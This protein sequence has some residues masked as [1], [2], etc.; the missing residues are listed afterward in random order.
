MEETS[1]KIS[2][3]GDT[4]RKLAEGEMKEKSQTFRGK[5]MLFI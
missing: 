5:N 1:R 3:E 4:R 2:S